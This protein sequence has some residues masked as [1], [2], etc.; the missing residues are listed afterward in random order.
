MDF[1]LGMQESPGNNPL[2]TPWEDCTYCD[3]DDGPSRVILHLL[4][5][6]FLNLLTEIGRRFFCV[7]KYVLVVPVMTESL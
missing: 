1:G 5:V 6:K 3:P 7:S 4:M 2:Q